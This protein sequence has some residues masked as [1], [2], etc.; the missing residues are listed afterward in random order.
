MSLP[1]PS[2]VLLDLD[3]TCVRHR[4]AR[5]LSILETVDDSIGGVFRTLRLSRKGPPRLWAHK[6]M[7]RVRRKGVD[8]IVEP[9]PYVFEFLEELKKKKIPCVL[10]S[11][12]LGDGYGYEILKVFDLEK[13]FCDA[14]FR[15]DSPRAKPS[16]EV[17][18]CALEKSKIKIDSNCVVWVVGDRSKDIRAAIALSNEITPAKVIPIA[19]DWSAAKE[20]VAKGLPLDYIIMSFEDMKKKLFNV[21]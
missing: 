20:I 18:V 8:E 5:F 15:E 4:N 1:T 10:V 17:L 6:V 7:H 21:N 14:I 2:V 12:G 19:Y 9:C 11:N 13:Y 3:G 16:P